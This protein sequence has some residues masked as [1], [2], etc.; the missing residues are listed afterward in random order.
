MSRAVAAGVAASTV[1]RSLGRFDLVCIGLNAIVGS[2]V[3]ALPDDM[4]REMGALSPLAFL[5]CALGL[6]PVALCYGEAASR[7]DRNGG[8]Y[9][10]A[11][12]A[13][14]RSVGFGVGWMS[15]A[16]SIFSFAAVASIAAAYVGDLLPS[17]SATGPTRIVAAAIIA[18]FGAL[19]YRGARP[20]A[21]AVDLFTIGKFAVLLLLVAVLAP[22]VSFGEASS[23]LPRGASGIGAAIFFAVFAAQGFEVVPIT[24]GETHAPQRNVPL[25]VIGSLLAASL[26]YVVVQFV[27]I[28]S[29]ADLGRVSETPLADAAR[30]HSP[31][32][33]VIV[34]VGGVISTLGFV[35]GS[36][37]GT[38]RYLHAAAIDGHLHGRL[39]DVHPRFASPHFAVMVTSALAAALVLALDYRA[40]IGISNV[41][42]AV[43]Y[44]ATCLAVPRLR[45][46]DGRAPLHLA[47]GW[48]VPLLG[49]AVSLW[50]FTAASLL[51]LAWAAGSLALGIALTAANRKLGLVLR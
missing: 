20:G 51:E 25:A 13:F 10:Y 41:A 14:G 50:I 23:E 27:L 7:V 36:A 16:N 21:H 19:N 33:G 26:L 35:S 42:V 38:P 29:F 22:S 17:L 37:L 30:A 2:G 3:F 8:P 49:A 6:L 40:L 46:L 31:L 11:S 39:G 28:G 4:Y 15:F 18:I 32:L 34:A 48:I 47:G 1:R 5:A 45:R 12:Q 9:V 44:L 43:Q 24:A